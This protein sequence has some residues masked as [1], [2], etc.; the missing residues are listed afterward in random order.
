MAS[1]NDLIKY[2]TEQIVRYL[3]TPKEYRPKKAKESL[4]YQWFGFIPLSISMF[5]QK[6]LRKILLFIL[7]LLFMIRTFRHSVKGK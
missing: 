7:S 1:S 4:S 3:D 6:I 2:F 5:L